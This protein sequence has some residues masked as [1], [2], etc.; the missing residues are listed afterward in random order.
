[1]AEDALARVRGALR[2]LNG[3]LESSRPLTTVLLLVIIAIAAYL[4]LWGSN[5]ERAAFVAWA[6]LP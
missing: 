2:D 4:L 6:L 5:L 1:M 3:K